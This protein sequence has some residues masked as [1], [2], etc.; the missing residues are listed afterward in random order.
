MKKKQG[1]ILI[2]AILAVIIIALQAAKTIMKDNMAKE[3]GTRANNQII[4]G[5]IKNCLG[6]EQDSLTAQI[7][8]SNS[9]DTFIALNTKI[10]RCE[11]GELEQILETDG[12]QIDKIACTDKYMIYFAG[13]VVN[14]VDLQS[15]IQHTLFE[16]A[17]SVSI[18]ANEADYI[19]TYNKDDKDDKNYQWFLF[20]GDDEQGVLLSDCLQKVNDKTAYGTYDEYEIYGVW[21]EGIEAYYISLIKKGNW[22]MANIADCLCVIDDQLLIS[23]TENGDVYYEY[24]DNECSLDILG[25]ISENKVGIYSSFATVC[26]DE[27]HVLVQFMKKNEESAISNPGYEKDAIICIS[28]DTNE[29]KVVY[30][31]S[32]EREKIVGY[33]V[34]ANLVYIYNDLDA[35]VKRVHLDNKEEVIIASE[36]P[37]N[38]TLYFEWSEAGLVIIQA[39]GG[40]NYSFIDVVK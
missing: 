14:R 36:L 40:Y 5:G 11:D 6:E 35:S 22:Q 27:L 26:D 34:E 3:Q 18:I 28:P 24:G 29:Q 20:C 31:T 7:V 39:D 12:K 19:I 33:D 10:Y 37:E 1:I 16:E 13:D 21:N 8:C 30:K 38:V 2:F 4:V 17:F 15:G 32:G 25:T 23:K 9:E